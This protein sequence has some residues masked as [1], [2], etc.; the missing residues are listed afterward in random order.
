MGNR[1]LAVENQEASRRSAKIDRIIEEDSKKL[2]GEFK[3][4]LLGEVTVPS[5]WSVRR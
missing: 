4:L 5:H 2:K 3:V 1:T